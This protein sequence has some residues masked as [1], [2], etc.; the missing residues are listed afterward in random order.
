MPRPRRQRRLAKSDEERFPVA[1]PDGRCRIRRRSVAI[2]DWRRGLVHTEEIK[3]RLAGEKMAESNEQ[4]PSRQGKAQR[5]A[6]TP[7]AR[8]HVTRPTPENHAHALKTIPEVR[9]PKSDPVDGPLVRLWS[10][11]D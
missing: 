4:P 2:D 3:H 7:G 9:L 10:K 8:M 6:R 5:V 1:R 11:P